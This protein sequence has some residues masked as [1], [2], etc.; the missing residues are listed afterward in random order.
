[1]FYSHCGIRVDR[2][3]LAASA[4]C[5]GRRRPICPERG[6]IAALQQAMRKKVLHRK[7]L[8]IISDCD[9]DPVVALLAF[10]RSGKVDWVIRNPVCLF[11]YDI[12]DAVIVSVPE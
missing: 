5:P 1:M 3:V 10:A 8:R 12:S 2:L 4:A 11:S 9:V 6:R 7:I